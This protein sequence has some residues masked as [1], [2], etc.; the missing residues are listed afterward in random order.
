VPEFVVLQHSNSAPK[1]W[2]YNAIVGVVAGAFDAA[3]R[4]S[5]FLSLPFIRLGTHR[6]AG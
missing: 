6:T 3:A 2:I 5:L 4:F 1:R